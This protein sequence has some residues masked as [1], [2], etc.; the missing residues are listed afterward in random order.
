MTHGVSD[1]PHQ[2][3]IWMD[4][5][6]IVRGKNP[7]GAQTGL[8]EAKALLADIAAYGKGKK[9]LLLIDLRELKGFTLDREARLYMAG[10]EA[11]KVIH[12]FAFLIGSPVSKIIGN[13]FMGVNKPIFPVQLF[14]S[15][16]KAVDWL[17]TF[18]VEDNQ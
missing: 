14:T 13:F 3:I 8:T 17:K 12:A 16:A 4:Q 10:N 11:K 7:V 5:D 9:I 1:K 15:E 6:G 18:I 2:A